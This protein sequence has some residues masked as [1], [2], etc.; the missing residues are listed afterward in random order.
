MKIAFFVGGM[1][2]GGV[3]TYVLAL[4]RYLLDAGHQVTV[5]ACEAG[6][7]WPRLAQK[8]IPG[9]LLPPGR[10]E[11]AIH[12]A[13]RLAHHFNG[14][15]YDVVFLNNGLGVRPAMVGLHRW[16]DSITAIPVLHNDL[17]R[18][19]AH[20]QI[21]QA[22]WNV[23]VAV[24]PKVGRS[25]TALMPD[26]PIVT[27]PYG[28]ALPTPEHLAKRAD[29]ALP[30]RLL[31]VGTLYDAHKGVMRLPAILDGCQAQGIS[32]QLTVLGAGPDAE[33]L[34]AAFTQQG[35]IDRV[36]MRG[37]QPPEAVQQAMRDHHVLLMPSN[38]EGLPLVSL[39]AQANGC[40]PV[41]SLL[42]GITDLAVET[43]V[44]GCLVGAGEIAGYVACIAGLGNE[45]GWSAF[46]QAAIRRAAEHFSVAV[47]GERYLELLERV[48]SG[49]YGLPLPRA[50]LRSQGTPPVSPKDLLPGALRSWAAHWRRRLAGMR[51]GG[52]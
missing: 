31:F 34:K 35:V 16:S 7:W 11:S 18:V 45:R 48:A 8:G 25:V 28:I 26:K 19:Y 30:L 9:V 37:Q 49:A 17:A 4:G 51:R 38:Y 14:G 1:G 52:R 40:V 36:E 2:V 39:E 42:P 5:V 24:S 21:N 12:H 15:G 27:I 44:S 3:T 6:P 23:A 50:L 29:W 41:A 22:A 47:M 43:G 13:R 20:A 33:R 46:S 32:V 10:W